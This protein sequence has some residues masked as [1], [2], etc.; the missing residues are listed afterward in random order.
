MDRRGFL[1]LAAL[2]TT[3]VY[4]SSAPASIS[5]EEYIRLEPFSLCGLQVWTR[6]LNLWE[7]P[8]WTF[9]GINSRGAIFTPPEFYI[10]AKGISTVLKREKKELEGIYDNFI[11]SIEQYYKS[12]RGIEKEMP[13]HIFITHRMKWLTPEIVKDDSL[14]RPSD[15]YLY[16][17][18]PNFWNGM[19][20]ATYSMLIPGNKWMKEGLTVDGKLVLKKV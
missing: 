6:R 1:K 11:R 19:R 10:Q 13:S 2:S 4:A 12:H 16:R 8:R 3:A 5:A 9:G 14:M 18:D 7:E 15:R 20:Q 17:Q